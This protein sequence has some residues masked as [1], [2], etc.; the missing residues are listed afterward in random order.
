MKQNVRT[1]F[2]VEKILTSHLIVMKKCA[3]NAIEWDIKLENVPPKI[4]INVK[5]ATASA[6]TKSGALKFGRSQIARKCNFLHVSN[7]EN[8]VTSNALKRLK[9]RK[10]KSMP[11]L[12]TI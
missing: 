2:F 4:L 9:A 6:T 12:S 10:S 11:K 3:L 1:V 8:L 7:V 5:S